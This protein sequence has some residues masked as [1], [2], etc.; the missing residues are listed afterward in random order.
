MAQITEQV[1]NGTLPDAT[2]NIPSSCRPG[3]L[4][5]PMQSKRSEIEHSLPEPTPNKSTDP[6]GHG[7]EVP[8]CSLGKRGAGD[9]TYRGGKDYQSTAPGKTVKRRLAAVDEGTNM[10]VCTCM[11]MQ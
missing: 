4:T 11:C 3:M 9:G 6:T 8:H 1:E 7:E 10:H 5:G 2:E